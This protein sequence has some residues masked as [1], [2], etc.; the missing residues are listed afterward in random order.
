MVERPA[1]ERYWLKQNNMKTTTFEKALPTDK[2][3]ELTRLK[4]IILG[5]SSII[6]QIDGYVYLKDTEGRYSFVNQKIRKDFGFSAENSISPKQ[7]YLFDVKFSK[8]FNVIDKQ[9]MDTGKEEKRVIKTANDARIY[10]SIKSPVRDGDNQIIGMCAILTDIT[11]HKLAEQE[12]EYANIS[13]AQSSTVLYMARAV[14][15]APRIYTSPNVTQFGYSVE[16]CKQGLFRFPDFVHEEDRPRVMEGVRSMFE[17]GVD[18]LESQYRLVTAQGDIRYILDRTKA[19][20]DKSGQ[21]T[22]WQGALTDITDRWL[23]E[24]Q[25]KAA[26]VYIDTELEIARS[27]QIDILPANFPMA[28][29]CDG[30][31]RMLPATTMGGDFYDFIELPNNKLGLVMADV[32]GKGIPAAFFMAVAR[33]NLNLIASD[34]SSPSECLKR[35]NDI[36]CTQ[37]PMYLFVT[38]FYA[39]FDPATGQLIYA[40]GGHNPPLLRHSEGSVEMLASMGDTALGVIEAIDFQENTLQLCPGD[41]L[42]LYTDGVTEAFNPEWEEYGEHRLFEQ[43]RLH[44]DLSAK[45]IVETIFEDVI[46]F[47]DSAPQSDDITITV[48]RWQ[49]DT[50]N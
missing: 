35:T 16:E 13:I 2:V 6:D 10:S 5:L 19:I 23:V 45:R 43:V 28:K 14:E 47:S 27:L 4:D 48:L 3:A 15:G 25:L 20:R 17:N 46:D 21:I 8:E 29:G 7:S 18:V 22:F 37:N 24:E 41:S 33:T 39:I 32:S 36:L 34:S 42:I 12:F 44:G 40:N 11:S 30:A 26:H 38:V 50:I 31:A 49:S 9:V 1:T